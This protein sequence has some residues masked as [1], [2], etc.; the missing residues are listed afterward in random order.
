[1]FLSLFDM[2]LSIN[3]FNLYAGIFIGIYKIYGFKK[4]PFCCLSALLLTIRN[5]NFNIYLFVIIINLFLIQKV[6]APL[7]PQV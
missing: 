4:P 3:L 6:S 2:V 1:M 5:A 7:A